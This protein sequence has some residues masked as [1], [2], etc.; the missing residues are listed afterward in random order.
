[1]CRPRQI[2]NLVYR[3]YNFILA[4]FWLDSLNPILPKQG[5]NMKGL[6]QCVEEADK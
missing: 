6:M 4:S 1:M 2:D 3:L 5:G